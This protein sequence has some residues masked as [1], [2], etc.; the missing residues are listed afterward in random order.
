[1]Q[2]TNDDKNIAM[3][4]HLSQFADLCFPLL[5]GLLL[6][7]LIWIFKKDQSSFVR[8]VGI[9]VINWSILRCILL[10]LSAVLWIILIG[11]VF[12]GLIY[13][14]NLFFILIGTLKASEGINWKIPFNFI[15]F[16]K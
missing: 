10:A 6:P 15:P 7:M 16:L 5:G 1:M 2:P 3:L 9:E 14:L 4:L 11:F 12:T 13:V 8:E